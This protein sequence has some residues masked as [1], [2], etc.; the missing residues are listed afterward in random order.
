MWMAMPIRQC[1][2]HVEC[3][4]SMP[5]VCGGEVVVSWVCP[6]YAHCPSYVPTDGDPSHHLTGRLLLSTRAAVAAATGP[7]RAATPAEDELTALESHQ[8]L[9]RCV[10]LQPG[11][12]NRMLMGGADRLWAGG[13]SQ[14]GFLSSTPVKCQVVREGDVGEPCTTESVV[15]ISIFFS[16]GKLSVGF[17]RPTLSQLR[18]FTDPTEF[19]R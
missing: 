8:L 11:T 14:A 13:G 4:V 6:G 15:L 1:S 16:F 10:A 18:M 12:T 5:C 2:P 17:W 7:L 3:A 9:L 19:V